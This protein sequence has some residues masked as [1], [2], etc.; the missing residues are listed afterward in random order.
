ML[1]LDPDIIM[2]GEMRDSETA[3]I[4]VNAAL[5]GHLVLTTLHTNAA[6]GA[7]IRLLDLGVQAYL[8]ASTLRC[9]VAQRLVRRLCTNCRTPYAATLELLS[10]VPAALPQLQLQPLQLWKAGGC[11]HCGGTGYRGRTAIFEVLVVDEPMRRLIKPDTS[12]DVIAA[13]ARKAGMTS[14]LDDGFQK[15]VEGLTTLDEIGRVATDN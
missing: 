11:D 12:A 15:C 1:R 3:S 13:A 9:A 2:V 5:T 6:A 10:Q 4:G 7:I 14:M 8:I